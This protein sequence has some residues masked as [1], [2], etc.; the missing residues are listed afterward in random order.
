MLGANLYLAAFVHLLVA[1]PEGRI[2]R[3]AHRR[4]VAAGYALAIVG[5]APFLMFGFDAHC[6]DCPRSVIQVSD[7]TTIGTIGDALTTAIAVGLVGYLVCVLTARWRAA[8]RARRQHARAAAVVGHRA[9]GARRG[10]DRRPDGR[11]AT[12][13]TS[14]PC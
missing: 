2:R 13:A 14:A 3:R 6:T 5:P 4:L 9:D 12:R 1:Y 8:G 11:P 10:L 7:G